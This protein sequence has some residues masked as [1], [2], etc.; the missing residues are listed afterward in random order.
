[1]GESVPPFH[2]NGEAKMTYTKKFKTE[3]V[4]KNHC[5]ECGVFLALD[6][7]TCEFNLCISCYDIINEELFEEDED[8]LPFPPGLYNE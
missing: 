1:M 8:N 4:S 6:E 7:P 3:K 2:L 5:Q